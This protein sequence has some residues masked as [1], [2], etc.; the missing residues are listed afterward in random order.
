MNLRPQQARIINEYGGGRLAVSAVPGSG[1][2]HTLAALA[3][4]LLARGMVG[5]DAEVLVVTFTNSAVDNVKAR[6]RLALR[7]LGLSDGGFRVFTLHSLA[8]TIVRERPDLAGV[9]FDY[10]I[11]D[12]LSNSRAM[13]DAARWFIQQE[14]DYWLSFLPSGLT[15]Q[16]RYQLESAWSDDTAR[17]GAEVTKLAKQLRLT[18][19]EVRARI[20]G[21]GEE[22]TRGHGDKETRGQEDKRREGV[23]LFL[24]IGAA[25]YERYDQTL[26]AGGRLDF[27]DLIWAAI[28]ALNNDDDFRR[29]LGR[30][31]PFILEDEA[32]DSTPLQEEI[33]ALL[34]RE[35]GNWVRVGDPNQAIMTTFTASDVRF[36][37]AFKQRPDV[38]VMPLTVSGRSAPEIIA[39]ANRL[40]DWATRV[41]PEPDVRRGA[42]S[43]DEIIQPTLPGD[44][45]PNPPAGRIRLQSFADED[46]EAQKVAQSAARFVLGAPDKT[47][48]ILS[49]T[50]YFGQRIVQ[51]LE[52]IQVRYPQRK[53]YQD[54]LRNAQ[55]VRDVARVLAQAVRFCSQPTNMNSLVDLRAAMIEAGVGPAG[56]ARD[57]RVKA[58]L[59]SARPERLL[60]PSPDAA[61]ALPTGLVLREDE[62]RE[63]YALAALAARWLRASVLPVDQLI[64]AIAQQL[65]T[66]ENDLA[67]VHSLASSLRRY[68][69]LHPDAHLADVVRELD[70]IASN[71]QRYL[72]SSLIEAG[73]QPVAGQITVTT[74]HKAK[75][76]EWD[77]VYLTCVDEIEFPHDASSEFRG[78]AWYLAGHDPAL[79]AR[80]QLEALAGAATDWTEADL[81]RRA[82]LEY[83]AERLRLLYVGITRARTDLL[84]SYS[85][86]RMERDNSVALAVREV[87]RDAA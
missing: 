52:E 81:V 64:L 71:R 69:S 66:R 76:L 8:N 44:P 70:E 78:Q 56:D 77:R 47:C 17:V 67:I 24:R 31:W 28:R 51:A 59:R 23:S 22:G 85:R 20:L 57:N 26:H 29:R 33:L 38:K 86:R 73:F 35:H 55:P 63:V 12:E 53:L 11:D 50:N 40:V 49:P 30:R 58:L 2:T 41:H 82:H 10:R 84:I 5:P 7:D 19:A 13:S 61:P 48:A 1:K 27:D 75:G 87:L 79:E 72:S 15:Q 32:Q 16:Q 25:I 37:R 54:Q 4:H 80:V 36:F 43:A 42:L 21:G 9:T 46:T 6:I 14:R 3:A 34:S 60:F 74:M 39:L 45:Q 65:F 62:A 83:V 18:P 68:M